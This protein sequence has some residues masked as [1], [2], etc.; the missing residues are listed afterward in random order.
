MLTEVQ[1]KCSIC[2]VDL[3]NVCGIHGFPFANEFSNVVT[4]F[5]LV[6]Y[7]RCIGV[8][9]KSMCFLLCAQ[10]IAIA[11]FSLLVVGFYIFL[12]PFLWPQKYLGY[13]AIAFFT[14]LVWHLRHAFTIPGRFG[15]T[16]ERNTNLPSSH[17]LSSSSLM[18]LHAIIIYCWTMVE[19][20]IIWS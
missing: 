9:L 5:W 7:H 8:K 18:S 10:V 3:N 15:G 17:Y 20:Y 13:V 14:P 19:K 1:I 2:I 16:R 6:T 12:A 11:I 4:S